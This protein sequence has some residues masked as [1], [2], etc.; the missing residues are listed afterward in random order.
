MSHWRVGELNPN[1]IAYL[2]VIPSRHP[3]RAAK[4][5]E[6]L[7][8]PFKQPPHIISRINAKT[9]GMRGD[10]LVGIRHIP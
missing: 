7:F 8:M 6:G 4:R 3:E 1:G 5:D 2:P 10:I 9:T